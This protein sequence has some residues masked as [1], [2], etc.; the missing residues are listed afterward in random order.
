MTVRP[1]RQTDRIMLDPP[2]VIIEILSPDDKVQDSLRRFREYE[3]F[4]VRYI[5]QMDRRTGLH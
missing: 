3:P 4:P 2:L 1:F 5:V